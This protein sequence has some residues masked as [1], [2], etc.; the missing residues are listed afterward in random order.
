MRKIKSLLCMLTLGLYITLGT[1]IPPEPKLPN[2]NPPVIEQQS[3]EDEIPS[4]NSVN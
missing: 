4:S 3:E 2:P 1:I